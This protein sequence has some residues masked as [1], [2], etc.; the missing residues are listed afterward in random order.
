MACSLCVSKVFYGFEARL[1]SCFT[2]VGTDI[3]LDR[4]VIPLGEMRQGIYHS[5]KIFFPVK[6]SLSV[7]SSLMSLK[8]LDTLGHLCLAGPPLLTVVFQ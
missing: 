7:I 5:G 3:Y 6:L 8:I 4:G 2:D 1:E